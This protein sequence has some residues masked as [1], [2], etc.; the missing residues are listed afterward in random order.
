MMTARHP[1]LRLRLLADLGFLMAAAV[2]IVGLTTLLLVGADIREVL[3]PLVGLWIGSLAVF[4]LFGRYLVGRIVLR[5]LERLSSEADR[6]AAGD[7]SAGEAGYEARELAHLSE[8]Y[9]LMAEDL[10]DAQ[11]QIV[12]VEKLAGIG[13][14]AAGVAHEV[15]NPLGALSTY[16]E[17]LRHR[18]LAPDVTDEMRRAI[19]RIECI[20]KSLLE[21]ARPG[22]PTGRTDLRSAVESTLG[23][24]EAQGLFRDH[25]V[26]T[27]LAEV[28]CVAGDR[29]ALE[30]VVLNL[31]VNA[32]DAAPQSRLWIDLRARPFE[33]RE[34]ELTR[35][36]EGSGGAARR[37]EFS[38]RPRRPDI[39]DGTAGVL[40][41]VADDGPG[42]PDADR[43][44]IFDPF[45][46]TRDPGKGVGLGLAL[47]ARTIHEVGGTVW[48]DRAREGG[49]AFKVF[50]PAA[51]G[52]ESNAHSHR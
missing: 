35:T 1:S 19:E 17:V 6:Y 26:R 50:L 12:R 32:C 25:A 39:A 41:C 40:L 18:G 31:V 8:R 42:V 21:Y 44:R 46:T 28:P 47:V 16:T 43:E 3:G 14:L 34:H 51:G 38:P 29:H 24:L 23:F 48:V 11:S 30:Q 5:P 49:A 36:R 15:R 45:Y 7:V 9:R 10:L 52:V 22:A 13:R 4:V 27:A 33:T 20:V 2:M 37:R